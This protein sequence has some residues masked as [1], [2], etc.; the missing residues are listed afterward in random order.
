[1]NS[2]EVIERLK[3]V[4]PALRATGVGSLRLFGSHAR[5]EANETSDIDLYAEAIG[6]QRLDL[7]RIAE[8]QL[9]IQALFPGKEISYSARESISPLYLPHIESSSV[10][11]F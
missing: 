8:G 2:H 1:M 6:G 10:R 3:S 4:E 7:I 5:G 11:V 9:A